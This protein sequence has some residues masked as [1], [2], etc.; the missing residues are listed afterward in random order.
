MF[1]RYSAITF[2][3]VLFFGS[4]ERCQ[5]KSDGMQLSARKANER[6]NS[7]LDVHVSGPKN[8]TNKSKEIML[9]LIEP[10]FEV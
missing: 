5:K 6:A 9:N 10:Q 4:R 2:I 1:F 3:D 8:W 7:A